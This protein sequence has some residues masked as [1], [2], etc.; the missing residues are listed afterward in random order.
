M[1]KCDLAA[2]LSSSPITADAA[3]TAV[4]NSVRTEDDIEK[5][6]EE[7]KGHE[8]LRGCLY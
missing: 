7:F 4:A 2:V 5:S 8:V 1:G 3:A 6:L